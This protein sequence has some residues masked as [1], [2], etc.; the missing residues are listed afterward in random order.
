MFASLYIAAQFSGISATLVLI[1]LTCFCFL[2]RKTLPNLS[3]ERL[4]L[5]GVSYCAIIL[6]ACIQW[7]TPGIDARLNTLLHMFIYLPFLGL[8]LGS[9][10]RLDRNLVLACVV[11]NFFCFAISLFGPGLEVLWGKVGDTYR[12]RSYFSEPAR[13]AAMYALNIYLVN[14]VVKK[15][16]VKMVLLLMSLVCIAATYS[17]TGIVLGLVMLLPY[18]K[19]RAVVFAMPVVLLLGMVWVSSDEGFTDRIS[20]RVSGILAGEVDNSTFQRFFAPFLFISEQVSA[21]DTLLFGHGIGGMEPYI[22]QNP[23]NY[24]F[25]VNPYSHELI[26]KSSN[27]YVIMLS[28]FGFPLGLFLML[29]W[30][31][32]MVPL[33]RPLSLKLF[34]LLYPFFAAWLLHPFFM[35]LLSVLFGDIRSRTNV[36]FSC[37]ERQLE[38]SRS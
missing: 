15:A 14:F 22:R 38:A 3:G 37:P 28:W 27:G 21:T 32:L 7:L 1:L 16:L 36:A 34:V 26:P 30:I 19:Q 24:A 5:L 31:A 17:G 18:L 13:A 9:L 33:K 35:L 6:V 12:F 4:Y 8:G 29:L 2:A 23:G 20:Q 25:L 10:G 11:G